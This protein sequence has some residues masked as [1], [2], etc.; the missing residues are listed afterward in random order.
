MRLDI[1]ITKVSKGDNNIPAKDLYRWL[2][3]LE[4]LRNQHKTK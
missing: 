3:E 2:T 4:N 1:A